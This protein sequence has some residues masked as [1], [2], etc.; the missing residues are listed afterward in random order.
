MLAC[1][2]SGLNILS[3]KFHSKMSS[4]VPATAATV[5]H[6]ST[7]NST[8]TLVVSFSP[9]VLLTA[10]L[11]QAANNDMKLH[12]SVRESVKMSNPTHTTKSTKPNVVPVQLVPVSAE[13]KQQP[14]QKSCLLNHYTA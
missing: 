10:T 12:Q 11:L 9:M 1:L 5:S 6:T 3:V 13:L 2:T 8:K 7:S 4:I 14:V